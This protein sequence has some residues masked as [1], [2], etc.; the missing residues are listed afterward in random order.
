MDCSNNADVIVFSVFNQ[1]T[2]HCADT[3]IGTY[4]TPVSDF[5]NGYLQQYQVRMQDQGVDDYATPEVATYLQCTGL[6]ID[7][8]TYYY[9]IGC[10]DGTTQKMAVHMYSDQDCKSR[11]TVSGIESMDASAIQVRVCFLPLIV[12]NHL[13]C[14]SSHLSCFFL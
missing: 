14:S 7:G 13:L 4:I 11:A 3:P 2:N 1:E 9:Q 12:Y 10:A 8:V 6:E 5:V